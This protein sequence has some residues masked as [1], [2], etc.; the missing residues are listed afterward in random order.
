MLPGGRREQNVKQNLTIRE[1][2]GFGLGD[3]AS[4]I[5]YQA[6]INILLYFYTDV[7][8]IEAAA[9]GTLLLVVRIFDAITDPAMGAIA[10][11]TRSKHG[12]YRPWML[13]VAVPY[14]GLAVA[15]FFTPDVDVGTKLVYAY[16]SYALLM[17][18]YTA[19]NVP[20]S[21]LGGVMTGD[22]EERGNL[23][24]WRFAMAMVGGFLVTSSIFPLAKLLGGGD[25]PEN[26][27]LG[28]PFAMTVMAIIAVFCF[29]LCFKLTREHVPPDPAHARR[30]A[31]D[32]LKAMLTNSQWLVIAVVT[33][34]VMTRGAMQGA[35]KPYFVN[36]YLIT[37]HMP[38]WLEWFMGSPSSR[39]SAFLSLT[40][41]AG[42]G[43]AV[44][45]NMLGRRFCK[46]SIMRI[47]MAGT[48][49]MNVLLFV[50]PRDA[51]LAALLI[52]MSSNFFHMMFIPMLFSTVPDTVDYGLRTMGKGAMA[53]FCGG[54]LFVLKLGNAFGG[55]F[56]GHL[57]AWFGYQP[58][59]EQ[60]GKALTG[61]ML[62]FAGSSIL[63][64]LLVL[65]CL[66]F[67]R[68]TRGW[69]SRGPGAA[70]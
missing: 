29:L 37:D 38:G 64:A 13:W 27:R 39:L 23:Q 26:Y 16:I 33:L 21:A 53:M 54:H 45:A 68:L 6:V 50:I 14:G 11:R 66:Q 41:L 4:N 24:T 5:V 20:Y 63:S 47:A 49:L 69:Q 31:T 58:N 51:V 43:G 18:A 35:A 46:V 9:A 44:C 2:L 40:M 7:Y 62:A 55:F 59:V 67:Y 30:K 19:V 8:G 28:F 70:P 48:I 3:T 10:D 22:S 17:T 34:I 56:V 15:A 65:V 61:I 12:R 25:S 60:T 32:D 1:K 57:L 52:L 36:Y 42:V